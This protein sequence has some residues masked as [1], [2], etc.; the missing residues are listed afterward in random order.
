MELALEHRPLCPCGSSK[1][2]RRE[3]LGCLAFFISSTYTSQ[4]NQNTPA[5]VS[6]QEEVPAP[7]LFV[8]V[9]PLQFAGCLNWQALAL[10]SEKRAVTARCSM[11]ECGP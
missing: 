1:N 6:K 4:N 11:N 9:L 10:A 8:Q 2:L 5:P 3:A 7:V